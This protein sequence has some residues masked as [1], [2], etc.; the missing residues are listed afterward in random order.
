M[1][2]AEARAALQRAIVALEDAYDIADSPEVHDTYDDCALDRISEAIEDM[3][4]L[5]CVSSAK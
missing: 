5:I 4:M 3:Q 1:L 2:S